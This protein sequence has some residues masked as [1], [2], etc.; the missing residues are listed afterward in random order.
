MASIRE[1]VRKDGNT[2][3]A[4]LWRD[5]ETGKQTSRSMPTERDAA[6]LRD[7]LNANGNS[8]ALAA[9][10]ASRLRSTAPTV[11]AVLEAHIV[12]LT[13]I[14]PDTRARYRPWPPGTSTRCW[15]RCPWIR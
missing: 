15:A 12:Q 2:T 8:F 7:F 11:A 1:R 10:A 9:Q 13:A 4:V 5:A 14:G 6:E 3:W